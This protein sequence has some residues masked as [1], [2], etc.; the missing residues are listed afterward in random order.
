MFVATIC[1]SGTEK[2]AP[3]TVALINPDIAGAFGITGGGTGDDAAK[4]FLFFSIISTD[5]GGKGGTTSSNWFGAT[6]DDDEEDE[7]DEDEEEE[8]EE[9]RSL[10]KAGEMDGIGGARSQDGFVK[11]FPLPIP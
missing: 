9:E 4:R 7:K 2:E 1:F 10:E 11:C 8:V 3:V 5:D 6:L